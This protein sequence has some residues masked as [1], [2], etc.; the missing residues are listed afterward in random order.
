MQ[1]KTK[2]TVTIDSEVLPRA[3]EY[4]RT[5][6]ASLSSVIEQL[7]RDAVE[8]AAPPK[9]TSSAAGKT[10]EEIEAYLPFETEQERADRWRDK[11][12]TFPARWAGQFKPKRQL[13]DE[14][15]DNLR[16]EYHREKYGL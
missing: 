9:G 5:H 3:K 15:L 16:D 11:S 13:T 1:T 12:L 6:G 8:A 7:L 4:A 10:L 2:L 14:D